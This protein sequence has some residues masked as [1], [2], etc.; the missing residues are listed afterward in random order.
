MAP[1]CCVPLCKETGGYLFPKEKDLRKKWQVAIKRENDRKNLWKPS[2]HSVV[3]FKH[4]RLSDFHEPKVTYGEK[5]RNVLKRDAVPSIF[6]FRPL[7]SE[8]SS[9]EKRYE[10][11]CQSTPR[12]SQ[13]QGN[14]LKLYLETLKM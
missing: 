4:F 1:N 8:A 11:R 6:P 10:E 7:S 14:K 5:R 12:E 3:C 9:R 2:A 13:L